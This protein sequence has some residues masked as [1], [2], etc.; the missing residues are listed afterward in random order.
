M[1]WFTFHRTNFTLQ[2]NNPTVKEKCFS[3]VFIEILNTECVLE[4]GEKQ[5][6]RM[7]KTKWKLE[8]RRIS[9]TDENSTWQIFVETACWWWKMFHAFARTKISPRSSIQLNHHNFLSPSHQRNDDINGGRKFVEWRALTAEN[10]KHPLSRSLS[11][12]VR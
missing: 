8:C 6:Q 2:L 9:R 5:Q 7:V 11:V 3:N 4:R 12:S 10:K 1:F